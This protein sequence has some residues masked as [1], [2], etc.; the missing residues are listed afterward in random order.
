MT[1]DALIDKQ[2]TFEIVRDQIASILVTEIENQMTLATAGGKDPNLWKIR[3]FTER[4]NAV[5]EWLNEP[6]DTSPICNIWYN[7]S[8]FAESMGNISSRQ[9]SDT[10]YNLDIF[11]YGT[12]SAS[13]TGHNA[14]DKEAALEVQRAIRLIRNIL[15]AGENTFLQLPRGTVWLR[16]ISNINAFQPEFN[17]Q[18]MQRIQGARI[19]FRVGFNELSPQT[20]GEALEIIRATVKRQETGEVY[21]IAQYDY[22]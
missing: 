16:W 14:G 15:M 19:A 3:V 22:S 11:G 5:E 20:A 9:K 6:I 8:S 1:L 10:T 4:S 21:F 18:A 13:V 2:D 12:S 17:G 7:D